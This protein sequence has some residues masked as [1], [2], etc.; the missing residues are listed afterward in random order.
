MKLRDAGPRRGKGERGRLIITFDRNYG[1]ET[2]NYKKGLQAAPGQVRTFLRR[3]D[4]ND[5]DNG[6]A[7]RLSYDFRDS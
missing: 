1:N 7:R 5:G 4:A 6:H 3:D 2:A